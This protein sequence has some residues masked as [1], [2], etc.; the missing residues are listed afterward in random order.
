MVGSPYVKSSL[1]PYFS[2]FMLSTSLWYPTQSDTLRCGVLPTWQKKPPTSEH[3]TYSG[4]AGSKPFLLWFSFAQSNLPFSF[5]LRFFFFVL[6]WYTQ[7]PFVRRRW[8]SPK[9]GAKVRPL[10]LYH[11]K[12]FFSPIETSAVRKYLTTYRQCLFLRIE[13]RQW[14]KKIPLESTF[15]FRSGNYGSKCQVWA[16]ATQNGM[17]SANL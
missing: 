8:P 10:T 5:I 3:T 4:L 1:W 12:V 2:S 13:W 16:M 17:S 7:H 6:F 11:L 9:K 15:I 14:Q